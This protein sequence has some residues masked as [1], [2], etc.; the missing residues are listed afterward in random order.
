MYKIYIKTDSHTIEP[1]SKGKTLKDAV[2]RMLKKHTEST[3]IGVPQIA[4]VFKDQEH[5]KTTINQVCN[6]MLQVYGIRILVEVPA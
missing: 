1:I 6:H 5:Q 2:K 3:Y 4:E